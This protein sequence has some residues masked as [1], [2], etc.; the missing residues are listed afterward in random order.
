[1]N[2]RAETHAARIRRDLRRSSAEGPQYT[3]N[4]A[5][6]D[7]LRRKIDSEPAKTIGKG[8]LNNED[9]DDDDDNDGSDD[10][11]DDDDDDNDDDGEDGKKKISNPD[12]FY[13]FSN[14]LLYTS[15]CV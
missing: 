9:D 4:A 13:N 2:N 5:L 12:I 10:H 11:S 3:V 14:C 8:E 1:M 6:S 15:R 7:A